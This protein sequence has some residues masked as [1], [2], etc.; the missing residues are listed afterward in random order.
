M[1]RI[2]LAIFALSLA[3][4]PALAQEGR[5]KEKPAAPGK[6]VKTI[7]IEAI[8]VGGDRV[9]G[10]LGPI[11]VKEASTHTSLIRIRRDFIDL[12][13]KSGEQI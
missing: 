4:S 2:A 11:S 9:T 1:K 12:I 8:E 5:E 13:L 7:N 10:Q 6:R 3:V